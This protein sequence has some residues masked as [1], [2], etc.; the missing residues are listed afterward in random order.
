MLNFSSWMACRESICL[1]NMAS[2]ELFHPICSTGMARPLALNYNAFIVTDFGGELLI[3][4]ASHRGDLQER[5]CP[6]VIRFH[7]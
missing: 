4:V 1:V 7:E 2:C 6:T 5:V 3:R